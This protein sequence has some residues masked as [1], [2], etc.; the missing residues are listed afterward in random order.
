MNKRVIKLHPDDNVLVA[1]ADLLCGE[2]LKVDGRDITLKSD[3]AFGHKIALKH[4]AKYSQVL[5]YGLPIG[6]CSCDITEG[7]WVHLHNLV[8]TYKPVLDR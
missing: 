6:L 5:K 8:S 3:I 7:E 1:L 2:V 4:L